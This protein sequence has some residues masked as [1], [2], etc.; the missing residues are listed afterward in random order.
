M[1]EIKSFEQ[2][3]S[4]AKDP[5]TRFELYHEK[6]WTGP[7][8]FSLSTPDVP[9]AEVSFPPTNVVVRQSN[10]VG[11]CIFGIST[12]TPK[13]MEIKLFKS[14][15][16]NSSSDSAVILMRVVDKLA[17]M[18][19]IEELVLEDGS[20]VCKNKCSLHLMYIVKC[21]RSWYCEKF[22]FEYEDK[23]YAIQFRTFFEYI[24]NI[25]IQ[26]ALDVSD[27]IRQSYERNAMDSEEVKSFGDL[28]RL[29]A[30][31]ECE[32]LIAIVDEYTKSKDKVYMKLRPIVE[33][34][35]YKLVKRYF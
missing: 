15:S 9:N 8:S 4:E 26:D 23:S 22:G 2:E 12:Y 13:T 32:T 5:I 1:S 6:Y 28:L 20:R 34:R 35:R 29:V 24:N 25:S 33:F 17:M 14:D 19:G 7:R 27:V 18:L 11:Q 30:K 3:L 31:Y 21:G 10:C 16:K